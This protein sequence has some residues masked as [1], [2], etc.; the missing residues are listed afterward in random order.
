MVRMVVAATLQFWP[1]Q[2][3]RLLWPST[4][5]YERHPSTKV[6]SFVLAHTL[7]ATVVSECEVEERS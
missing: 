2:K 3:Q 1:K 5:L 4:V 7:E 6:V